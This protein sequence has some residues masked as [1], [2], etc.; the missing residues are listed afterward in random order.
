[1]RR[2][3]SRSR[4]K[5]GCRRTCTEDPSVQ[6]L[7]AQIHSRAGDYDLAAVALERAVTLGP[8]SAALRTGLA[9]S[10][11]SNN[12]SAAAIESLD[13]ILS[14]GGTADR[15]SLLLLAT[16]LLGQSRFNEALEVATQLLTFEGADPQL[17]NL[18]GAALSSFSIATR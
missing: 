14:D 9:L 10:H 17:Y 3:R 11:L 4:S 8:D 2:L 18:S 13:V 15:R 16:L 5:R 1:M 12:N 6:V 7:L